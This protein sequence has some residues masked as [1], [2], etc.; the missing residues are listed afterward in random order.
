MAVEVFIVSSLS[1]PRGGRH[2]ANGN[3]LSY[4]VA[5]ATEPAQRN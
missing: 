3:T 4:D 2:F 1:P 5:S